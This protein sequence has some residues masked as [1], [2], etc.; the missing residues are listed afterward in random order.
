M[1]HVS[2]EHTFW[3]AIEAV[4]FYLACGAAGE[5]AN[6][7]AFNYFFYNRKMKRILYLSCRAESKKTAEEE[8]SIT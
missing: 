4:N 2:V 3:V 7:W 1:I 6:L 8:V 5:K